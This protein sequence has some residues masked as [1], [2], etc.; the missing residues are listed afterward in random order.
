MRS[1]SQRQSVIVMVGSCALTALGAI[2]AGSEVQAQTQVG[3]PAPGVTTA[4]SETSTGNGYADFAGR[5]E[6]VQTIEVRLP[7]PG[8]LTKI[9]FREGQEIQRGD[10]LF[11]IDPR[12]HEAVLNL[13]Q[14]EL[15]RAK[16]ELV[17][18]EAELARL[19][20]QS[21]NGLASQEEMNKTATRV[22]VSK[23][24]VDAASAKLQSAQLSLESTRIAS[25]ITGR[26]GRAYLSAGNWVLPSAI[27]AVIVSQDPVRVSFD[28]DEATFLDLSRQWRHVSGSANVPQIRVKVGLSTEPDFPHEGVV[29][30]VDNQFDPQTGTIRV[31]AVLPNPDGLLLP[32]LF[33]RIRMLRESPRSP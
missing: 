29:D 9:S 18:A 27:L 12:P 23:A 6:A 26:I 7:S 11:E 22:A 24:T 25:P 4:P 10:L 28:M 14:A 30:F 15:A 16:A 2:L 20:Q 1:V 17:G 19:R 13:A 21:N 8:L 5:I 33:A 3:A 32:G 31:R